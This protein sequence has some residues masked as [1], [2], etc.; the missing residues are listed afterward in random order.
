MYRAT[1]LNTRTLVVRSD[2]EEELTELLAYINLKAKTK[3]Q[4][5]V[6]RFLDFANGNY[7]TDKSFKFNRNECYER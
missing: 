2:V 7:A 3:K 4:D 1:A 6:N 5:L